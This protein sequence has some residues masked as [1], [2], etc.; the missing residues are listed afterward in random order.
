ME[1]APLATAVQL[2]EGKEAVYAGCDLEAMFLR[3]YGG[4]AS[5]SAKA[6]TGLG[7]VLLL[8]LS[9]QCNLWP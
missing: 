3:A 1:G 6:V 8:W 9:L 4:R 7:S 2:P 5:L